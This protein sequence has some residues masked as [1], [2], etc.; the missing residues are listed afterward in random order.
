MRASGGASRSGP[1]TPPSVKVEESCRVLRQNGRIGVSRV[2]YCIGNIRKTVVRQGHERYVAIE[3][4][5]YAHEGGR[6]S[7]LVYMYVANRKSLAAVETEITQHGGTW[8]HRP[9]G[10]APVDPA[11]K[12]LLL[13]FGVGRN[14]K[15]LVCMNHPSRG[16]AQWG[17]WND[18]PRGWTG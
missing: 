10:N 15:T 1:S 18:P 8:V 6:I 14:G 2:S 11:R 4:G 7:D 13:C 17:M 12:L 5:T 9:Y 3:L 16:R